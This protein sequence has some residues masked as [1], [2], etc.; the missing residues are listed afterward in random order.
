VA[1]DLTIILPRRQS[2]VRDGDAAIDHTIED[3]LL[4]SL[5]AAALGH[6]WL[7]DIISRSPEEAE[8]SSLLLKSELI[9]AA[10]NLAAWMRSRV[11]RENFESST[12]RLK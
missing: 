6:H 7:D 9:V 10:A 12:T 4:K 2:C 3:R 1:V 5:R 8:D 11:I